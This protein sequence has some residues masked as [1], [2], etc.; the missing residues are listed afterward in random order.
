M[1]V[2]TT[3]R[4]GR[5]SR[6]PEGEPADEA[7]GRDDSV[8]VGR[9]ELRDDAGPERPGRVVGP[10]HV[11]RAWR[12]VEPFVLEYGMRRIVQRPAVEDGLRVECVIWSLLSQSA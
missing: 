11:V 3:R 8:R 2:A 1:R 7:G 9:P 4:P 12:P 6:A 5:S 10:A